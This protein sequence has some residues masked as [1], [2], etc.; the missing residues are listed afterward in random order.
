MSIPSSWPTDVRGAETTLCMKL[1]DE[2]DLERFAE[3]AA[4]DLEAYYTKRPD[5]KKYRIASFLAEEAG[6]HYV[7][8]KGFRC[9]C[10]WTL[11]Q[12][13]DGVK[14]FHPM[15]HT[16]IDFGDAKFGHSSWI[17]HPGDAGFI[18]RGVNCFGR[19]L[20]VLKGE[21]IDDTLT[22]YLTTDKSLGAQRLREK[23]IV[24][25]WPKL[26]RVVWKA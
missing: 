21:T 15:R 2:S 16:R 8:K 11:F 9:I 19:S 26:G 1:F 14:D 10:L 24:M 5:L 12:R 13:I 7:T 22:R 3:I 6:E 4:V 23:S 25:L 17:K 18:G 20:T